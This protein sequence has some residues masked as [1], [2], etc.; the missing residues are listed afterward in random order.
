MPLCLCTPCSD[1]HDFHI[2]DLPVVIPYRGNI[3]TRKAS[4][5]RVW[6]QPHGV[7]LATAM[8]AVSGTVILL[9][10]RHQKSPSPP[11]SSQF[12]VNPIS[13]LRPCLSSGERKGEKKKK[14][15]RFAE[16][17]VDPT[18]NNEEFRRQ[19]SYGLKSRNREGQNGG[20]PANRVALYNGMLR[21]RV[22]HRLA[23]TY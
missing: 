9:A 5:E 20:M 22:I 6:G 19:R 11:S 14:R 17:V 8:A 10:L 18:G 21:D 12:Q 1:P 4:C 15:V 7:V 3:V 2:W 13:V 23:C 16:D